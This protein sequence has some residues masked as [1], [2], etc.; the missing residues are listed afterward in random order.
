MSLASEPP[1]IL[2]AARRSRT[3]SSRLRCGDPEAL[4]S[5]DRLGSR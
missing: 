3:A 5:P 1:S 2:A 4:L